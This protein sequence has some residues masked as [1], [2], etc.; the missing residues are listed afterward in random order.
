MIYTYCDGKVTQIVNGGWVTY[1]KG[2]GLLHVDGSNGDYIER[3]KITNIWHGDN[4]EA[5]KKGLS[6]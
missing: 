5:K 3:G 4:G 1:Y 6:L 2:K